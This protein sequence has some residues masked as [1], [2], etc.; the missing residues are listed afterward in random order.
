MATPSEAALSDHFKPLAPGAPGDT[1]KQYLKNLRARIALLGAR[2]GLLKTQKLDT[3]ERARQL[4]VTRRCSVAHF[5]VETQLTMVDGNIESYDRLPGQAKAPKR[6]RSELM[7]A[8]EDE[9]EAEQED[10]PAGMDAAFDLYGEPPS[11][12]QAEAAAPPSKAAAAVPAGAAAAKGAPADRA[13]PRPPNVQAEVQ[14]QLAPAQK[15]TQAMPHCMQQVMEH[16]KATQTGSF[17]PPPPQSIKSSPA[18]PVAK[19]ESSGKPGLGE[20]P[21]SFGRASYRAL[22]L[23]GGTFLFL[24][25]TVHRIASALQTP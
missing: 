24:G 1:R 21:P 17:D 23:D 8:I 2:R 11:A 18:S 19:A 15:E 4:S 12:E 16:S 6:T 14:T 9:R 3:S 5:S 20:R 25:R 22:V 13:A 7:E 10:D